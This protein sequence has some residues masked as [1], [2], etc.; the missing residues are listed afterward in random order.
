MKYILSFILDLCDTFFYEA[1][2][3]QEDRKR[4]KRIDE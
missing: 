4:T 1:S 3:R 2:L